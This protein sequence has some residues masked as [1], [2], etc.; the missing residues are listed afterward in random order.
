MQK[1]SSCIEKAEDISG[2]EEDEGGSLRNATVPKTTF[3]TV[4]CHEYSLTH[5]NSI[6]ESK[7]LSPKMQHL[8]M[9]HLKDAA[10]IYLFSLFSHSYAVYFGSTTSTLSLVRGEHNEN[11][12]RT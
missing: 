3:S 1:S 12:R 8:E 9:Q 10:E 7:E 4:V 2:F 5:I 6:L 11:C